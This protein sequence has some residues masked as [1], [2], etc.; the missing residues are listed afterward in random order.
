MRDYFENYAMNDDIP[1]ESAIIGFLGLGVSFID[2]ITVR[3]GLNVFL[4]ISE[5]V[6]DQLLRDF[7]VHLR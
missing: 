4:A 2:S 5:A 7:I 3:I 6:T 1:I